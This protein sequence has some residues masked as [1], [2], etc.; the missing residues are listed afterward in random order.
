MVVDDDEVVLEVTREHLESAGFQVTTR[1]S[2]IG[3]SAAVG[4]E[5]PDIVLLDV[6]IPGLS[7]DT[8]ARLIAQAQPHRPAVILYSS[9]SRERLAGLAKT[10]GAVGIIEKTSSRAFFLGQLDACLVGLVPKRRDR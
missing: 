1:S 10:C 9:A 2:A 6:N 5:E 7:G 8:L 4:R 3:T